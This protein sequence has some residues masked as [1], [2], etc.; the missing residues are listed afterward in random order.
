MSYEV[1]KMGKIYYKTE[2]T[3]VV[4]APDYTSTVADNKGYEII[5]SSG[6]AYRIEK[7]V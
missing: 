5:T 4:N 7:G 6:K 3:E 2:A 1:Q